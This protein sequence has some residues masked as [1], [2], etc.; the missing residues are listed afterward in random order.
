MTRTLVNKRHV[1]KGYLE[2]KAAPIAKYGIGSGFEAERGNC[3]LT[4]VQRD[5]IWHPYYEVK[6][7]EADLAAQYK[8]AQSEKKT[9]GSKPKDIKEIE[10]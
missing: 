5:N 4:M 6:M 7:E 9:A 1:S 3:G 2:R 8:A 10:A